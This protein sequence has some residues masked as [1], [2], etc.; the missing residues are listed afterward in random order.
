MAASVFS[1]P[2]PLFLLIHLHLLQYPHSNKPEYDHNVFDTRIRGLRDRT[3]TME[4]VCYFLVSRIA[5]TKERVRKVR[6]IRIS[7][8]PRCS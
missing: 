1:L 8:F 3:R 7:C 4:D 5:G 2:V 6:L